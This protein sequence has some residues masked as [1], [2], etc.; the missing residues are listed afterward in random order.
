VP[1][2]SEKKEELELEKQEPAAEEECDDSVSEKSVEEVEAEVEMAA[3]HQAA[4]CCG[5]DVTASQSLSPKTPPSKQKRN[6]S[7]YS[8][9]KPHP[10]RG[11]Q[12]I[13]VIE[14]HAAFGNRRSPITSARDMLFDWVL[15]CVIYKAKLFFYC[16]NKFDDNNPSSFM[17]KGFAIDEMVS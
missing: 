13:Y 16:L 17:L 1:T 5:F 14:M 7:F 11:R 10:L 8:H 4:S 2:V 15:N 6:C 12:W 9:S 3:Q